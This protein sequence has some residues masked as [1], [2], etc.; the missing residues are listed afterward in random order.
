MNQQQITALA[1]PCELPEQTSNQKYR[2]TVWVGKY[3]VSIILTV[4]VGEE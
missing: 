4:N 1:N 2:R 3:C